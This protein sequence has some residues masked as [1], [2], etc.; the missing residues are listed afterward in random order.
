MQGKEYLRYSNQIIVLYYSVCCFLSASFYSLMC[1][2]WISFD[3]YLVLKVHPSKNE[4]KLS[5]AQ[6]LVGAIHLHIEY[7]CLRDVSGNA[8]SICHAN[9]LIREAIFLEY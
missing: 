6:T 8:E 2:H 7:F 3:S 4:R 1:E 9:E 5:W